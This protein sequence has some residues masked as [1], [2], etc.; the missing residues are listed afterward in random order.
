MAFLWNWDWKWE[1]SSKGKVEGRLDCYNF[2]PR[3]SKVKPVPSVDQP[4]SAQAQKQISP[5]NE[6]L[7]ALTGLRAPVSASGKPD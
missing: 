5:L 6:R 3:Q 7:K 4:L 1:V 2:C